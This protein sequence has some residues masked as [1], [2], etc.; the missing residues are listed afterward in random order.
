MKV[1]CLRQR[2][3]PASYIPHS[4]KA[5]HIP[6]NDKLTETMYKR[7]SVSN[8]DSRSRSHYLNV[9]KF[10]V[11]FSGLNAFGG[12]GWFEELEHSYFLCPL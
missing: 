1:K 6:Q 9:W 4:L 2:F 5:F 7:T 11:I 12:F 8:I 10:F 3:V